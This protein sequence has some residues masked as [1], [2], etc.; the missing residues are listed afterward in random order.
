MFSEKDLLQIK[1]HSLTPEQVEAQIDNFRKG[2]PYLKV[3]R[4]AAA[5]DGVKVLN[6]EQI[7]RAIER[8]DAESKDLK[9]VKFVPASGAATRMFKELFEFV[10]AGKRGKGIDTLLEN[11]RKFAFYEELTQFIGENSTDEEIVSA[12]IINGLAYGSKPK[13]LVTFHAYPDGARKPVEEHLVEAALYACNG[14]Q[15]TIHFTVSPEHQ[16]GFEALL[17]ERQGFYEEKFG[18]KFDISFSQQSPA[19]DTIAVNPD[20]TPFRT[21]EGKLL[22]RPAGHG[23]L[24]ANLNALDAD[25][26]FACGPMPM[27]R[28]IKAYAEEHG[29]T[30]YVSMEERMACGIGACLACVCKTKE[31]DHHTNVNN[32]R[33]CKEGPVFNAKEVV[34]DG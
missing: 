30:C 12:I 34:W 8:Y 28:A 5:G 13:G 29:I 1:N 18:K 17:A 31:K 19:T 6:E 23:A 4:A 2:F 33:I 22:F 21:A 10:G 16:A 32:K 11:I 26:I 9:I 15:A 24:L 14:D 25:V 27:L 7:S 20:N 3:V